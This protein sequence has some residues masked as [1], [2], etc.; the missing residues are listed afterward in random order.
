MVG[1]SAGPRA[2]VV[3]GGG[4]ADGLHHESLPRLAAL[5]LAARAAEEEDITTQ[6][7]WLDRSGSTEPLAPTPDG[8]RD[9]L[10]I[11]AAGTSGKQDEAEC[12]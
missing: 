9:G 8:R 10:A 3:R 5:R 1:N 7:V 6:Q 11:S 2:V 4:R 12:H